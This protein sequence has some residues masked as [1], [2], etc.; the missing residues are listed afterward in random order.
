MIPCGVNYLTT[1]LATATGRKVHGFRSVKRVNVTKALSLI[2]DRPGRDAGSATNFPVLSMAPAVP[3]SLSE[4]DNTR[5]WLS[6]IHQSQLHS[7]PL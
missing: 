7:H 1:K 2:G 5:R 6:G 4:Y 3:V